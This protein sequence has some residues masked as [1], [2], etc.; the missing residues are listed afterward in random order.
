M[1]DFSAT[2]A[3]RPEDGSPVRFPEVFADIDH[4]RIIEEQLRRLSEDREARVA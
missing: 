3:I 2:A 4:L 1:S